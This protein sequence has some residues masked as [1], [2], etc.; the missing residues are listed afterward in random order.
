MAG[1]VVGWHFFDV[2]AGLVPE[3]SSPSLLPNDGRGRVVVLAA[4]PFAMK[5]GWAA[6]AA[7]AL[8]KDWSET[9]LR[10]FLMDLGL[11]TPTL[12]QA[13]DLPN[14]E[15]VADAFLY[16][17]S[18]QHIAKP[19]LDDA[20]FF[21]SAGSPPGN[22]EEVLGHSRWNDLAGGFSEANATLL[23]FL[24]TDIPGAGKIL[25]RATD[26]LFFAGQGE[27][28]DTHLGPASIKAFS[29][30]GP[31]G[32]PPAEAPPVPEEE[33][34]GDPPAAEDIPS[35]Q[36]HPEEDPAVSS[37][38]GGDDLGQGF[39][40]ADGFGQAEPGDGEGETPPVFD[41]S[42]GLELADGFGEEGGEGGGTGGDEPPVETEEGAFAADSVGDLGF[43]GELD[44]A[45][46]P[47]LATGPGEESI[48][49]EP[50][51]FGDDLKMGAS[52]A[53]EMEF[54]DG[55]SLSDGPSEAPDFGAEFADLG[56]AEG[57]GAGEG[58]F[59]GELV[60]GPD[61]GG[62]APSDPPV[63]EGKRPPA[64]PPE[65]GAREARPRAEPPKKASRR[66]KPPKKKFP[67]GLAVAAVLLLVLAGAAGATAMGYVNIPGLTF[68]QDYFG[69]VPDPPLTLAGPQP[70][71]ETLRFSLVLFSYAPE[72][73][74]DAGDMLEA[75]RT[76]LPDLL[77]VLSSDEV[78]GE[79]VHTLLAGPALDRI[80]A[81]DL[82]SPLAEVLTRE[83]PD[84]WSVRETG[85]AFFLGERATPEEALDYLEA[86]ST[87]VIHPYILH[88]TYP[89]ESEGYQI[90]AG[91]Y[92]GVPDARFLQLAL[93]DEGFR[94]APLIERRGRLPE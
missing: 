21:A 23:L 36:E 94:D 18:V 37:G 58:E 59:G 81:E 56:T 53:G 3:E 46:S 93:R 49:E 51:G 30:L 17:A 79:V 74:Q 76:R 85:R 39:D 66:R 60:Q 7:V 70:M 38:M 54:G 1:G 27:L 57:E 19:V 2:E 87:D 28:P 34:E 4:T 6:R 62:P 29:L 25:S 91:A 80:E 77:F 47:T 14:G 45:D 12:H 72:E 24:P 48:P 43:G 13:L 68:L 50:Q 32:A 82:R 73:L 86:V 67:T 20:F 26:I 89:D 55:G 69:E 31:F 15:G 92:T 64:P 9:G 22:P 90:L 42:G 63:A 41:F 61:F 65:E 71:E 52:L 11:E 84:S 5:D 88:V 75:L 10:I 44:L 33:E 83:D 16:G 35:P 40:L 8:A 78:E